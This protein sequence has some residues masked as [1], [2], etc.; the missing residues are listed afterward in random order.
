MAKT[1]VKQYKSF[2]DMVEATKKETGF[3]LDRPVK[4]VGWLLRHNDGREAL[5]NVHINEVTFFEKEGK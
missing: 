1:T 4:G 5:V 3:E 2:D